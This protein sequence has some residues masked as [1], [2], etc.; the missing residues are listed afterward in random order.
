MSKN[1]WLGSNELVIVFR[2]GTFHVIEEYEGF[3]TVFT[4]SYKD[5]LDYCESRQIDY[6]ESV[7]G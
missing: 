3:E 1:F 2:N 6:A 5:C 7:I 4:G